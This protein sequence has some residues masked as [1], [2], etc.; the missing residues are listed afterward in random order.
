MFQSWLLGATCAED[1]RVAFN[2]NT[3]GWTQAEGQC[4]RKCFGDRRLSRSIPSNLWASTGNTTKS[5]PS[6]PC[7][8]WI[9]GQGVSAEAKQDRRPPPK[10]SRNGERRR[11]VVRVPSSPARPHTKQAPTPGSPATGEDLT[12]CLSCSRRSLP[13]SQHW[14]SPLRGPVWTDAE[15]TVAGSWWFLGYASCGGPQDFSFL[16]PSLPHGVNWANKRPCQCSRCKRQVWSPVGKISWRRKLQP[17]P[18]LLPGEVYGQRSLAGSSPWE[19]RV[20]PD[21]VHT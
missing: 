10:Q 8:A 11:V 18:V 15:E 1:V 19:C 12:P 2:A 5:S 4:T 21:W 16:L 6:C 17:T 3:S 13:E 20:G 7:W 9:S 14:Y